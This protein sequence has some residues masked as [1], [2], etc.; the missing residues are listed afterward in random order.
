MKFFWQ[1]N[2]PPQQGAPQSS[3]SP[4]TSAQAYIATNG[5]PSG[6]VASENIEDYTYNVVGESFRHDHLVQLAQKHK[7]IDVGSIFTSATLKLEPE[8]VFDPTAVMVIVEGLHVG[9]IAK[10]QSIEMTANIKKLN[11]TEV[12][13]PAHLGWDTENPQPYIGVQLMLGDLFPMN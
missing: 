3:Q 8:N 11:T 5:T 1:K 4:T 10:S 7:A 12:E 9:Y 13:V 6:I 2:S